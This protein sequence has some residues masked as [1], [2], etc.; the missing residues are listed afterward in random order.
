MWGFIKTPLTALDDGD[1]VRG[2][3]NQMDTGSYLNS[4]L[5]VDPSN[6]CE[7]AVGLGSPAFTFSGG[8]GWYVSACV[9]TFANANKSH[10]LTLFASPGISASV[11][12]I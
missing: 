5:A 9:L 10:S 4:H 12:G 6:Q 1:R 2:F 7:H 3:A 11:T 8:R